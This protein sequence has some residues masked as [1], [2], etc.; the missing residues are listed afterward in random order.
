MGWLFG[1]RRINLQPETI[2]TMAKIY[3]YSL[4]HA[5]KDL[6]YTS[7]VDSSSKLDDD[8]QLM[9]NTVFEEEEEIMNENDDD[10]FNEHQFDETNMNDKTLDIE[11]IV[12]LGPWVFINNSILPTITR[13]YDS[14]GEEEWDLEQLN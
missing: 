9:L 10:S 11:S 6:N 7:D 14:D 1:K 5:K 12:D 3:L 4:K 8:I 2:E 13:R